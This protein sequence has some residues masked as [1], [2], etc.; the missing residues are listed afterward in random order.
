MKLL[1]ADLEK[2]LL[3][4]N[5]TA[6]VVAIDYASTVQINDDDFSSH[7]WQAITEISVLELTRNLRHQRAIA[8][9]LTYINFEIECDAV[10]VLD[11]DGEDNLKDVLKLIE[12]C[13]EINFTKIVFARRAKRS[14]GTIFRLFYSSSLY[15]SLRSTCFSC[16]LF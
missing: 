9:D 14:E 13:S 15:N 7:S 8:L 3:Q 2:V 12:K 10:I 5:S 1:L 11:A 16:L 6:K 4:N